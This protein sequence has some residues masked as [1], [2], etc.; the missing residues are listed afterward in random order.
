[1]TPC[2]LT[3]SGASTSSGIATGRGLGPSMAL[4]V[5][6]HRLMDSSVRRPTAPTVRFRLSE[7]SVAA[8][9]SPNRQIQRSAGDLPAWTGS[10][11]AQVGDAAVAGCDRWSA[12]LAARSGTRVV[13]G[14]PLTGRRE[15]CTVSV[16]RPTDG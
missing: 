3:T 9:H 11:Y 7:T 15:Q 4:R 8:G 10:G 5:H 13:Y 1:M 2:A 6:A 16:V 12:R 14:P